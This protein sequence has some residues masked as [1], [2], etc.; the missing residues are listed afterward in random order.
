MAKKSIVKKSTAKP[1]PVSAMIVIKSIEKRATPFIKNLNKIKIVGIKT[2]EDFDAAA[3]HVRQLKDLAKEA[4]AEENK[5]LV[6]IKSL[7]KVTAAHFK[8]FKEEVAQME[9]DA[10]L[11]M[12]A[13][14]EKNKTKELKLASDVREGN[15]KKMSTIV[16]KSEEIQIAASGGMH[17][18]VRNVKSLVMVDASKTPREFLVPDE[19]AIKKALLNGEKVAGWKIEIVN[20]IAI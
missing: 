19:Q 20:S 11:L 17:A 10:K 4:V 15:V 18:S 1:S 2:Q 5:F 16:S 14:L 13:Y 7:M 12:G 8:P 3:L 9:L 6:P